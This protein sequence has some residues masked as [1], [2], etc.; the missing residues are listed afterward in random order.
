MKILKHKNVTKMDRFNALDIS[1]R[2]LGLSNDFRDKIYCQLAAILHL[3]NIEFER[4]SEGAAKIKNEFPFECASS[5]LMADPTKLRNALLQRS[6]NTTMPESI[7][8]VLYL[9]VFYSK[10]TNILASILIN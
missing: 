3:G 10:I 8:Y 6:L 4:N 9:T 5:L 7:V 2:D 1:L